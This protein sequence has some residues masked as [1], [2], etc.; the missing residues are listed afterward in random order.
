MDGVET[1]Q[2][3]RNLG[4]QY[5]RLVII[6]LTANAVSGA[7]EMFLSNG[8]NDFLSKPVDVQELKQV[9]IDWLPEEKYSLVDQFSTG[10]EQCQIELEFQKTLQKLF[11]KNNQ[12]KYNEIINALRVKD[13]KLA[14]RLVHSLKGN[15]G[16]IGKTRLQSA[17]AEVENYL[18]HGKNN[19]KEEYL[20]TLEIEL[21]N[22]LQELSWLFKNQSLRVSQKSSGEW[23]DEQSVKELFDK[24]ESLL[25]NGNPECLN[26]TDELELIKD[27]GILLLQLSQQIEDFEF[28]QALLTLAELR[29]KLEN[30]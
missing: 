22:V 5:C 19:V 27:D 28:E 10:A 3:I 6:A 17:A 13:V 14:H 12:E 11:V 23:L 21:N 26:L 8:F 4:S 16:Q 15:A 1:V 20:K 24:L 29:K 18:R 25:K 9:I 7:K 2:E 30:P